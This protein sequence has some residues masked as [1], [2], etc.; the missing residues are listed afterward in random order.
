MKV[1]ITDDRLT[2]EMIGYKTEGSAGIDLYAL[3][4]NVT[5]DNTIYY[6][7]NQVFS[8]GL[9][10][11]I[12][13]G[14]VGLIFP[15]SSVGFSGVR[16][17]NSVGVIDSDYRGEIKLGLTSWMPKS[18]MI[19]EPTRMAQLVILPINK[20]EIEIVEKLEKTERGENGFG[21]TGSN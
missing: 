2:P 8:T 4:N 6:G 21:S 16:L 7:Y 17:V 3:P 19:K 15:R 11:E 13:K 18:S 14:H 10:V 1:V 20:V 9:K 5:A 12:P